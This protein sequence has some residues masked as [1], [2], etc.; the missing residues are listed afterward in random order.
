M[1]AGIY[2]TPNG[3]RIYVAKDRTI[4]ATTLSPSSWLGTKVSHRS[5]DDTVLIG[6]TDYRCSRVSDVPNGC[7][8]PMDA[9][10]A[11]VPTKTLTGAQLWSDLDHAIDGTLYEAG[12][13]KGDGPRTAL[14]HQ[15]F[16]DFVE[17]FIAKRQELRNAGY[18]FCHS[19]SARKHRKQRHEVRFV[20][21]IGCYAWRA[22]A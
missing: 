9:L 10:N 12:D 22:S 6:G 1:K 21:E 3:N 7:T 5:A 20:P 13:E 14:K 2:Q 15:S 17:D 4:K 11:Y 19:Q 16:R 18:R 8:S